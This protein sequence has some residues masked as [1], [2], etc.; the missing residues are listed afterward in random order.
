MKTLQT[1]GILFDVQTA[2]NSKAR[3]V[4]V[5][6][7]LLWTLLAP[8]MKMISIREYYFDHEGISYAAYVTHF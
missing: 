8:G 1:N 6:I 5:S 4:F 2:R 3:F 7:G